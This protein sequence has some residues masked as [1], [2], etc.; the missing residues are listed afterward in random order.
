MVL[1]NKN[2]RDNAIKLTEDQVN[3]LLGNSEISDKGKNYTAKRVAN[4]S[5]SI[6]KIET[7]TSDNG[8]TDAVHRMVVNNQKLTNTVDNE[9]LA[10][11]TSQLKENTS[12]LKENTIAKEENANAQKDDI[13]SRVSAMASRGETLTNPESIRKSTIDISKTMTELDQA[14][15]KLMH[16]HEENFSHV[17]DIVSDLA[18]TDKKLMHEHEETFANI[19]DIV[20][21]MARNNEVLMRDSALDPGLSS[22]TAQFDSNTASIE[23]NTQA[24][25][26]NK[27]VTDAQKNAVEQET[28][29][30]TTNTTSQSGG[31]ISSRVHELAI[32]GGSLVGNDKEQIK[33]ISATVS[34]LN[35]SGI[36][37]MQ[38]HEDYSVAMAN[39]ISELD[40]NGQKL[41]TEHEVPNFGNVAQTV[42]NV[43]QAL[44][45]TATKAD[46]VATKVSELAKNN[47]VLMKDVAE[48][49]TTTAASVGK[50]A[51]ETSKFGIFMSS[52][53]SEITGLFTGAAGALNAVFAWVGVISLVAT[54]IY[55]IYD[56]LTLTVDEAEE[57]RSKAVSDLSE[58]QSN[59]E[60]INSEF[61]TT[62]QRIDELNGKD[63]LTFT[64][65]GELED[66][67]EKNKLLQLQ[68]DTAERI[69]KSKQQD[70]LNTDS[71]NFN[72]LYKDKINKSDIAETK[73]AY[74]NS[75]GALIPKEND[76]TG[77][78]AQ[79]Q[80]LQDQYADLATQVED[81]NDRYGKEHG[82]EYL[83]DDMKVTQESIDDVTSSLNKQLETLLNM[84]NDYQSVGI[85]N[86]TSTQKEEYEQIANAIKL[87]Y[88]SLDPSKYNEISVQD[89]FD[90]KDI[91][92]TKDDLI[93]LAQA[94]K[95]DKKTLNQY[96]KLTK[97]IKD[98]DLITKDGTNATKAF[99]NAIIALGD[100]SEDIE[101][102]ETNETPTSFSTLFDGSDFGDRISYLSQQ[103]QNG[104]ISAHDYFESIRN[105]LANTDFSE[106][107]NQA[108]AAQQFFTDSTQQVASSMS[109]LIN[110]YNK[111]EI[112]AT[113]YLDGYTSMAE[114]LSALTDD[115][116]NNSAAWNENGEAISDGTNQALDN[117]QSD[118]ASAIE[119]INQYQDSIYSLEQITSGAITAGS[120]EF[121]AHAQ[122]IAE[123]LAYIVQNGGYMADQIASTMGTTTSEIANSLTN[124]VDNQA[125]ASQ[126]IAGNTNASIEQM[127]NA[128][129]T[130]FAE[131]GNQIGN[132]KATINFAPKVNGVEHFSAI[133]IGGK[134]VVGGDIPNLTYDIKGSSSSLKSIGSAISSF[135]KV[136]SSNIA[137]Q[138]VDYKKFSTTPTDSS[139]K[140]RKYTPS[141]GVTNN[142]NNKLKNN[143]SSGKSG[144]SGSG[145]KNSGGDAEKQ[146]EEYLD[147]FMAYQKARLEAGKITYQQYSQYVSDEL[148][149]MYKNGEISAS[150]YY[151]A[152]KDM[153]DEQKSIYDAALKGVKK[154]LDDEI[155]KW[156]DKIDVIEKNNDKLNEQKDKYDSI[157]SAIQ[158]VYD[159]EI[160]KANKR[161]D[162]IQDIIDAMSDENDEYERQKKLQEAIYN[163]NKA[164]SQKTKYLLKDGQFVYSTDNSAIRDGVKLY[165]VKIMF[166]NIFVPIKMVIHDS[167][168]K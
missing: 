116:Q 54:G 31:D 19:S 126:A 7:S 115:L 3:I 37:L 24:K 125:L 93:E 154:L 66:L 67:K 53:G 164:N 149:R 122:V 57:A 2:L 77:Q 50:V 72:K 155:D 10:K 49:G 146:N 117:A 33:D 36:K 101:A 147:K 30:Q 39:I 76:I 104:K 105:E 89:I 48:V 100:A 56:A 75:I 91:E 152:V 114:T 132:F 123:D 38:E 113:E 158:K 13:S 42:S 151:S 81:Y 110:S 111:G 106:F 69:Q 41:M 118:L 168:N 112:S 142:Y 70:L 9:S 136:L 23:R 139:G 88:S 64:E 71:D 6:G 121:T 58:A 62:Q 133:K 4:T 5:S 103:F 157:L 15:V 74:K 94:G 137:S 162:S 83:A 25:L 8:I 159:D 65:Q 90:T 29:A 1:S 153:I 120:D 68:A 156:K 59:L 140:E 165:G 12:T 163:L 26:E 98:A 16:E 21:E 95:L 82:A 84:Q 130:L 11:N 128:V 32:N 109:N 150:K 143:K 46:N 85:D 96:P 14:G 102:N 134:E 119:G 124:S 55:K 17:S 52:L 45:S 86:L 20:S 61:E 144:K 148:E 34:E 108:A 160:E 28:I 47:E 27:A 131:L 43:E 73:Q 161:K 18:K 51:S 78:I 35:Q 141:K 145:G 92:T 87:I 80:L 166:E 99:I 127:A 135:G 129:S 138:K 97:A 22:S 63:K 60:S 44:T 79:L 107:T 167:S 40:Q